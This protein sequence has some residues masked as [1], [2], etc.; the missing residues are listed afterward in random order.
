M[1]LLAITPR[2]PFPL[3]KGDKLRAYHQLLALSERHEVVL[4]A[5]SEHPVPPEHLRELQSFCSSVHVVT[6]SRATTVGSVLRAAWDGTPLQVGY[7][8]SAAA[9]RSVRTL[10]EQERPDHV[11][12]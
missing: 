11:Y 2:F 6:R 5:L 12:S 3:E 7:F 9:L 4:V 8:R 10:V 1:K